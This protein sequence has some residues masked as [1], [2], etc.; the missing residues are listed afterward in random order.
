M[1]CCRCDPPR[2]S[3]PP[4]HRPGAP[5][6]GHLPE[7]EDALDVL[8]RSSDGA[9][10]VLRSPRVLRS[11]NTH[12]TGCTLAAAVAAGLARGLSPE[13][14][15]A[16]AKGYVAALIRAS[17]GL[18]LGTGV[19]RPMDHGVDLVRVRQ[20]GFVSSFSSP[21]SFPP[22]SAVS[23][24]LSSIPRPPRPPLQQRQPAPLTKGIFDPTLYVVT[25][26]R[27][28]RA[29]SGVEW[30]DVLCAV[31]AAVEGGATCVQ[32]REKHLEGGDLV[33]LTRAAVAFCRPRGV[34]VLV[35]DRL[36]RSGPPAACDGA[37]SKR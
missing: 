34:A 9:H 17:A 23:A 16:A 8:L 3:V 11:A 1:P 31:K 32:L 33:A 37:P 5:F 35:N 28:G 10:W 15:A 4:F 7:S 18:E 36:V 24:S 26:S 13:A 2:C 25:T 14:A 12:G 29:G 21:S 6:S 30:Q 27:A 20:P 22:P 19:Q